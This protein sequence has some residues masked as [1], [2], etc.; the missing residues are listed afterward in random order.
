[1]SV[2]VFAKRAWNLPDFQPSHKQVLAEW[3][4]PIFQDFEVF[5]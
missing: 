1:M 5:T 3:E 2:P 4:L